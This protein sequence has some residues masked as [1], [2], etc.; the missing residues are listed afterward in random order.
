MIFRGHG[1]SAALTHRGAMSSVRS[2]RGKSASLKALL[3][4]GTTSSIGALR[5]NG[6]SLALVIIGAMG[7]RKLCPD[8]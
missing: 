7:P 6:V 4:I 3:V 8:M 2:L 5:G 1:R